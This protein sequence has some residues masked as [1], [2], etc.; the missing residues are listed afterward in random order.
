MTFLSESG[1]YD[2]NL[3][4]VKVKTVLFSDGK[5]GAKIDGISVI[6]YRLSNSTNIDPRNVFEV[7]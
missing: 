1:R 7:S 6:A 3:K 5:K 2:E 4:H